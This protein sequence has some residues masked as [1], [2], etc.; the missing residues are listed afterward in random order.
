MS[1]N[2]AKGYAADDD[3]WVLQADLHDD[4]I[5]REYWRKLGILRTG[6]SKSKN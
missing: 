6:R 1:M 5:I 2:M 4:A 3:T